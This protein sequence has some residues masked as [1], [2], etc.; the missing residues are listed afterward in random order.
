VKTIIALRSFRIISWAEN[1]N[2]LFP[3]RILGRI[4]ELHAL[5]FWLSGLRKEN[6]L[7]SHAIISDGLFVP[8]ASAYDFRQVLFSSSCFSEILTA[9]VVTVPPILKILSSLGRTNTKARA[10]K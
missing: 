10:I 8:A 6:L 9:L 1:E 4:L 2:L 5:G 7:F 3:R